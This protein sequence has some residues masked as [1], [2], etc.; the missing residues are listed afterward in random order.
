MSE[1]IVGVVDEVDQSEH[2]TTTLTAQR[3]RQGTE[4]NPKP[5]PRS[6]EEFLDF[7]R[8]RCASLTTCEQV[9]HQNN[10][11]RTMGKPKPSKKAL[12]KRK[13]PPAPAGNVS[14]SAFYFMLTPGIKEGQGQGEPR[15]R[16]GAGADW[17]PEAQ[18]GPAEEGQAA[19]P[20]THPRPTD[21]L[22][23]RERGRAERPG[24]GRRA[25]DWRGGRVLPA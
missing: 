11:S 2:R 18:A 7:R 3:H 23:Q 21:G 1:E 9:V 12:G 19:R 25:G 10:I 16:H 15:G 17:A 22:R 6:R 5:P 4:P 24:R 20:E 13:A 8:T 14:A